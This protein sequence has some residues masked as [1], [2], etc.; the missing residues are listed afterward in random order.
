MYIT[1][2]EVDKLPLIPQEEFEEKVKELSK[3]NIIL[4][5]LIRVLGTWEELEPY[6]LSKLFYWIGARPLMNKY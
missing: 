2:E 4:R 5:R 6:L 3:T 1:Q